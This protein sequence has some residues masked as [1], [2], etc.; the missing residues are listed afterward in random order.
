MVLQWSI[1]SDFDRMVILALKIL[2]SQ[3][4]PRSLGL[5]VCL[6]TLITY[7]IEYQPNAFSEHKI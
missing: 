1:L 4:A 2:I 7:I 3:D 6:V 5:V